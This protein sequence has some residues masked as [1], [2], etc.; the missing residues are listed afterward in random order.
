VSSSYINL[1]GSP[2]VTDNGSS[3]V[4]AFNNWM[5]NAGLTQGASIGVGTNLV[6]RFAGNIPYS[7][8]IEI[9]TA[10]TGLR[11]Y[12]D[13]GGCVSIEPEGHDPGDPKWAWEEDLSAATLSVVCKNCGELIWSETGT[14]TI[15]YD[16]QAE[17]LQA[18]ATA[19]HDEQTYT[20]TKDLSEYLIRHEAK[21]PAIDEDG[22]YTSGT[23]AYYEL[24]AGDKKYYYT[25]VDGH[26][27]EPCDPSTLKLDNFVIKATK[28]NNGIIEKYIG[29]FG[30]E[31]TE[32]DLPSQ[33][34]NTVDQ[35]TQYVPL[36]MLGNSEEVF[37]TLPE[38]T[39]TPAPSPAPVEITDR[40]SI[41]NVSAR[42]FAGLS[43]LTLTLNA[44]EPITIADGAFTGCDNVTI[45]VMD[46]SRLKE[47]LHDDA[48]G[49]YTVELIDGHLYKVTATTWAEDYSTAEITITCSTCGEE[50]KLPAQVTKT[51]TATED[52]ETH[53]KTYTLSIKAEGTFEEQT[54]TVELENVPFF[55]VTVESMT[56]TLRLPCA[57]NA[58]NT[59]Y[60]NYAVFYVKQDML[61]PLNPPAGAA[62]AGLTD[63][64]G[65]VYNADERVQITSDT[66]FTAKWCSTW[67]R[68]QTALNAG[69]TVTV[70]LY[71]D[72]TPAEGDGYLHIPASTTATL[73]L[74]GYTVNRALGAAT[75]DGYV[76]R[77]DGDLYLNNGTV[78]GGNN[79]GDGGGIY[80]YDGGRLETNNVNIWSNRAQNGG[81][82]YMVEV[83]GAEFYNSTI[84]YNRAEQSGGGLYLGGEKP[85]SNGG[86]LG[87]PPTGKLIAIIGSASIAKNFAASSAGVFVKSGELQI[88]SKAEII[89]NKNL[90]GNKF[91]NIGVED[92]IIS[93]LKGATDFVLGLPSLV[94]GGIA[95][96]PTWAKG[97]FVLAAGVTCLLIFDTISTDVSQKKSCEHPEESKNGEVEWEEE[98]Y[99]S[100]SE[101]V[102]CGKCN[103][104][105]GTYS[106]TVNKE[107]Y[108]GTQVTH[109]WVEPQYARTNT[110]R[111]VQPF[112]LIKQANIPAGIDTT[113]TAAD[114]K[115]QEKLIAHDRKEPH[116][117]TLNGSPWEFADGDKLKFEDWLHNGS[118]VK[119]V[120]F[121]GDKDDEEIT[122]KVNW[123]LP[124][125][126]K[127]NDSEDAP[128]SGDHPLKPDERTNPDYVDSGKEEK[129]KENKWTRS[130][131]EF[132]TWKMP[133]SVKLEKE[134][135]KFKLVYSYDNGEEKKKDD[136][137]TID[138]PTMLQAEWQSK[139]A[140]LAADLEKDPHSVE[141]SENVSAIKDDK[142]I[143][144]A[145]NNSDTLDLKG[146]TL[147]GKGQSGVQHVFELTGT[148]TVKDTSEEKN[149]V[150]TGGKTDKNGAGAYIKP[151][152]KLILEGGSI[153]GNMTVYK[154]NSD[155]GH[156]GGVY[157]NGDSEKSGTFEMKGG[158]V[159]ENTAWHSG[160]GVYITEHGSF[161][162]SGGEITDNKAGYSDTD[163]Q[164]KGSAD[165]KGGGVYVGGSFEISGKV[166]I[167][168]NKIGEEA[169][170]VYLPK[171][172][173]ITVSGKLDDDAEIHVRME[174]PGVIT[175]GLNAKGGDE[176]RGK[177]DNFV[178]DDE[179]Y[180]VII[181]KEGEAKLVDKNAKPEFGDA[182]LEL[183]G[184][185]RMRFYMDYPEGWETENDRMEFNITYMGPSTVKYDDAGKDEYGTYFA[186]PVNA[187]Q[188]AD[189]ISAVYYHGDEEIASK[190]YT[191][192]D[193]LST[194][195][196]TNTEAQNLAVATANYGHYIQPYLAR[197]N[198]WKIG[199]DHVEMD[200]HD[201]TYFHYDDNPAKS[202]GVT[203]DPVRPVYNNLVERTE[204]YVTLDSDTL[205][206][207]RLYLR[208]PDDTVKGMVDGQEL[209]QWR[210]SDGSIVVCLKG[211]N[212]KALGYPYRFEC[213]VNDTKVFTMSASALAYVN[214]AL[215]SGRASE[216]E[217]MALHALFNYAQAA[218]GYEPPEGS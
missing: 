42:A 167:K 57:R 108:S 73:N 103:A 82:V 156:G 85:E 158:S 131:Y 174:E 64:S 92:G 100:A 214:L 13:R 31:K 185:L 59:G 86:S 139:W 69:G 202:Y 203:F 210:R 58:D 192:R 56:G 145:E 122:V 187:F 83:S 216:E 105:L 95:G 15:A 81:G 194:L 76:I 61:D 71:S 138:K 198:H 89:D 94:A 8:G 27:G 96:L 107:V 132:T 38:P 90:E 37:Y 119:E 87:L 93:I 30:T 46:A 142:T 12:E 6:G 147:D 183:G 126:Y 77:V 148:L 54:Y 1:S 207:V 22:T 184:I 204:F 99:S 190:E 35:S 98:T 111:D 70:T 29:S 197:T 91:D 130:N 165:A 189:T 25:E 128:V 60:E 116:K 200:V 136:K 62:L 213:F 162:M 18:V 127:A 134:G 118:V 143:G 217:K 17:K 181:T 55:N 109:Y 14:V 125:G 146:K 33:I 114:L 208:N 135:T 115:D 157:I 49:K 39:E 43:N 215:G 117:E 188:M 65:N 2:V 149:G 199:E 88:G 169:N 26:P 7:E 182:R 212:A 63:G 153:K 11:L 104:Y 40:G 52:P 176:A 9:F 160:G 102:W 124:Y 47:G 129:V 218:Q 171:D 179:N 45:R 155:P 79:T 186:C 36:K 161:K 50:H 191:V 201:D 84:M 151:G 67:A 4:Y 113:E 78:T 168:D 72:I 51:E 159:K 121:S 3:N 152:G 20:E 32:I 53:E 110:T 209:E 140:K 163:E 41:T 23:Q 48:T 196:K 180:K 120:T 206:N 137:I 24:T 66:N 164:H 154:E 133:S 21:E 172:K 175:K 112:K 44:E 193:Y 150:V 34:V 173:T 74:G 177:A 141:M 123:K 205:L 68:V 178:S 195:M 80:I 144:V 19:T 106:L 16:A 10:D 97:L 5:T 170:N 75:A 211:V 28:Q 101:T 166:I